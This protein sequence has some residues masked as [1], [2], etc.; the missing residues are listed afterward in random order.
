MI[1][2]V[3]PSAASDVKA[4]LVRILSD[5]IRRSVP[6]AQAHSAFTAL[7][8]V[9]EPIEKINE[10]FSVPDEPIPASEEEDQSGGSARRKMRTWTPYEDNRLL[11]AIY[12]YGV[13][14]WAPISKFVG[15]G[16]TRAQCAQRWT[17]GLN[18]RISK[19]TWAPNE[20]MRL[21]QLVEQ[22]GDKA[23]TKVACSMGNRS[24]VQCRYHYL[25][26]TK[27]MNQLM[28][29]QPV[30]VRP[31]FARPAM[32]RFSMPQIGPAA[33][34]PVM[35]PVVAQMPRRASHFVIQHTPVQPATNQAPAPASIESLLNR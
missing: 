9:S 17:R 22:F 19:E 7:A 10:I 11:A 34:L 4:A 20:E 26:L 28:K 1:E 25:Q 13:D 33:Q 24:D 23:W 31:S 27:D 15:N 5:F 18:P 14:N 30:A 21:I 6:Y 12:R 32:P 8:G 3:L 16:R 29:V 2:R 35:A